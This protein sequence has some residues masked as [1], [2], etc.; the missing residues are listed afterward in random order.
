MFNA[1]DI[2]HFDLAK[3]VGAASAPVALIIAACI[4]LGNLTGKYGAMLALSRPLLGE[5]HGH[6]HDDPQ[7]FV[8]RDQLRSYASRLRTLSQATF[9]LT[10]AILLFIA[11]VALTGLSVILCDQPA[12]TMATAASM[13]F[14]LLLFS[15]AVALDLVENRRAHRA[16]LADFLRLDPA[17]DFHDS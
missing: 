2:A 6:P 5:Y 16:D 13:F 10:N 11:T 1:L 4:F 7:H 17:V 14:G 12:W 9:W 15:I 3:V 8:I